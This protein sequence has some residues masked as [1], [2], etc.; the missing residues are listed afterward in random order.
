MDYHRT[1]GQGSRMAIAVARLPA[2][3]PVTDPRYGGAVVLNPGGPGGSGATQA[4]LSGRNLQSIADAAASPSTSQKSEDRY[5]D[6]IGF[7]PRGVNNTTPGFSCFPNLFSQRNW[8]LQAEAD[9]I[10]GSSA[11]SFMRNWQRAI[12]LNT[13]CSQAISTPPGPGQEAL[14]EHINTPPVA[15]DILEIVER[16]G[17]WR[18]KQGLEAQRQHD[19]L[20]GYDPQQS[21]LARSKWKRGQEK[22]LYW[23]RSYGT[24]LGTT[25]ATLF[26]DRIERMVLDG[27]VDANRYY[28]GTGPEPVADADAIFEKFALY[29]N[30]IGE[31]CPFY[32]SGGPTGIKETYKELENSLLNSSI[33][34]LPSKTRGPEVVT[35]TDL[36]NVLR[37]AMY[38]PLAGFSFL[39]GVA[40][41]LAQGDGSRL[42]D[43]KAGRRDPACPSEECRNS[44]PW[45]SECRIPSANEMYASSAILCSDADYMQAVDEQGFEEHWRSLQGVSDTVGDYWAHT[46]LNCIGWSVKPKW[47]IKGLVT[48]NTSHPLLFVNNILDPVTPLISAKT[49]HEAFPGSAL[50]QQDSEGHCTLAA[51]SICVSQSIRK[52]FQTGELPAVETIC[53]ADLKPLIGAPNKIERSRTPDEETLYKALLEEALRPRLFDFPL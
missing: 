23:G 9:G 37:I 27:V 40:N 13:G 7:D 18:E 14:G 11:D 38:Q 43:F 45:S 1:D 26:P 12:A 48:G 44:G 15:R 22:L 50:L 2:K 8:E 25:F 20:Y 6:I 5:F 24:V 16:H 10:L 17:E 32:A 34:V 39:A 41:D 21:L 28:S 31:E 29:C 36:K 46:H 30:E 53:D 35:W 33:A 4:L 49:M 51:P 42:A 3:V 47:T 52:Y 19:E